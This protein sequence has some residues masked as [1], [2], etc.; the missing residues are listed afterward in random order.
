MH[1]DFTWTDL[2]ALDLGQAATFYG[3]VLDW[4]VVEDADGYRTCA[5]GGEAC[6]GLFSMPAVFRRIEMPSFWMTYIAVD[7]IDVTVAQAKELGAKVELEDTNPLGRIALIRDP[8]GAGFTC[9][10]GDAPSAVS[11]DR[12]AGRW[13]GSELFVSGLGDVKRFYETLFGWTLRPDA[14]DPDRYA[15]HNGRGRRIGAV[16]VAP[17]EVKGPKE[18]WAVTFVAADVAEALRQTEAMGGRLLASHTN[19]DG[20]HHLIEDPQG[21]ACYLTEAADTAVHV[22]RA[23]R[24][25]G[26][27]WRTVMGLLAVYLAVL[28]EASW[29]WGVLF[30]LW[31]LPDLRTGVTHF[32]ERVTRHEHPWLYWLVVG[33]WLV[34]AGY[35]LLTAALPPP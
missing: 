26:W 35:V 31:V 25:A 19:T 15:I 33:T 5:V 32:M 14:H 30:L 23:D 10:Q 8:A 34:L 1:G 17:N 24:A 12:R 9:Y 3:R 7:D 22:P 4:R 29:V 13:V 11:P 20:T 18:Y 27:K 6:A 21:A 28:T 2:S 16:Q